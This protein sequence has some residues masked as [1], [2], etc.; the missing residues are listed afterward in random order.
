MKGFAIGAILLLLLPVAVIAQTNVTVDP[1]AINLGFVN[2]YNLPEDGGAFQFG[3]SWGFADLTAVYT[4]SDLTLG[5]NC[6]GDVNEYW[7]QCVDPY[8]A[9]DCGGPGAPGNKIV[10][11]N[12]YAE[13][14]GTLAGQTVVFSGDVISYSLTEAHTAIAFIKDFAADYGS[15]NVVSVPLTGT[16]AFTLTLDTVN[17]PGRH[18][19]WGFQLIGVNVWITDLAP[20]GT[21]TIGPYQPV[22]TEEAT[23]GAIKSLIR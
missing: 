8:V 17:D 16:G 5:P 23:W 22:G 13:V 20:F 18:V 1:A 10:E 2:V 19:Q 14:T 4:G 3:S 21:I 7:Y 9:P 12:S 6:V 11:A 15:F